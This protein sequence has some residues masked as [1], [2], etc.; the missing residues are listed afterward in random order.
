MSNRLYLDIHVLQ[1]LPPSC[2]NRDDVGTP[3]KCLYGGVERARVSS[4]AWKHAM[5]VWFD[6]HGTEI[7]IR[8]RQLI[9]LLSG[10]L[11]KI[12]FPKD[13]ADEFAKYVMVDILKV[14]KSNNANEEAKK[15]PLAFMSD[16]Q[17][18]SIA[19]LVASMPKPGKEQLKK[20]EVRKKLEEVVNSAH[21]A[22]ILLFGRMYA[23]NPVLDVD[24]AA[25]V[26]HSVS[27][28]ETSTQYDYFTAVED[29]KEEAVNGSGHIGSKSFSSSVVYRYA[30]VNLGEKSE[31]IKYSKQ[32]APEIAEKFLEA[33]VCSMPTGSIN[34]YAN[35]TLPFYVLAVLRDDMPISFVPAFEK[36]VKTD[37]NG[38]C[39]PSKKALTDYMESLY[40]LY[41][42]PV[43]SWELGNGRNL[44]KMLEEVRAG[45]EG[46][47]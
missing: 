39:E 38:Y 45:I 3:K 27:T 13:N 32:Q 11:Q 10:K 40:K 28:H 43:E 20:K 16:E 41:G 23:D 25:Q 15:S 5:R 4:Q 33:F 18:E 36:P 30:A 9:G 1:V 17:I 42:S 22:D 21:T 12:G 29:F 31:L 7:G 47:I 14:A 46:R 6:E 37:S 19:Q 26:A 2:V 24:A 35:N 34:S 8:T 44:R